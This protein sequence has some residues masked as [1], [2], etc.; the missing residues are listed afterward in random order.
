MTGGTPADRSTGIRR[1]AFRHGYPKEVHT[2]DVE[3]KQLQEAI[4]A[5]AQA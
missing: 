2:R 5:H 1:N 3:E 4:E